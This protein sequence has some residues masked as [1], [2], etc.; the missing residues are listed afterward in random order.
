M[1]EKKEDTRPASVQIA[2]QA[3]GLI[4]WIAFLVFMY[5]IFGR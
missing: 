3:I 2:S 4:A 5:M 1:E